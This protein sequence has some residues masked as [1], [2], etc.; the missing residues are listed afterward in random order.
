MNF[1][2]IIFFSVLTHD[3]HDDDVEKYRIETLTSSITQQMWYIHWVIASAEPL[4]V[5]ARSVEFGNISLATWI[6]HPVTSLI[7]LILA[8]PLPENINKSVSV[9][10]NK[11]RRLVFRLK[12]EMVKKRDKSPQNLWL[13]TLTMENEKYRKNQT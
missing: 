2:I 3:N 1:L 4:S 5:T 7:S 9:G 6:E 11:W 13:S 8:P 10:R 12:R